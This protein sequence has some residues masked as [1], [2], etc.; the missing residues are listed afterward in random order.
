MLIE[1]ELKES[2]IKQGVL[3]DAIKKARIRNNLT[4]EELAEIIEVT[5][6]HLKHMESEHRKPSIE[7][8]FK[9]AKALN[10]SLDN[11]IFENNIKENLIKEIDILL[12][13]CNEKELKIIKEMIIILDENIK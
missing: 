6:T 9:L 2:M 4:Q 12:K 10:M 7:V 1:K 3:G 13:E 5:P 8:L 11:L